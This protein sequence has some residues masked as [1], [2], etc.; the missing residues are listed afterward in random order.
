MVVEP[1]PREGPGDIPSTI[2][3]PV[4][5][6]EADSDAT[7]TSPGL[8]STATLESSRDTETIAGSSAS[9]TGLFPDPA[10][11]ED[12]EFPGPIGDFAILRR[13]GRGSFAEVY[14]ARQVSLGRLVALKVSTQSGDEA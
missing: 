3:A 8:D 2:A 14:L 11:L 13:L 1:D 6:T 7:R 5:D 9:V 10:A 12:E 4:L